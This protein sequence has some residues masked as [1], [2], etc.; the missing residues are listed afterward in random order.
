M[1]Y[2][3]TEVTN[4]LSGG[5]S[6]V[7]DYGVL[8][9]ND[10]IYFGTV[11]GGYCYLVEVNKQGSSRAL[12][13]YP[14]SYETDFGPDDYHGS[15]ALEW[16]EKGRKILTVGGAHGGFKPMK[17]AV[18]DVE[19][20]QIVASGDFG[21][22][23]LT[24]PVLVKTSDG[25]ISLFIC[26]YDPSLGYR[27]IWWYEFDPT[28]NTWS[29]PV[30]I[31]V[32]E[33]K[34]VYLAGWNIDRGWAILAFS[35]PGTYFEFA[36]VQFDPVNKKF[37]DLQ[38][39]ELTPPFDH[40]TL[41]SLGARS[42]AILNNYVY[43]I[44]YDTNTSV[45]YAKKLTLDLSEIKSVELASASQGLNTAYMHELALDLM[46]YGSSE[47]LVAYR[48]NS[49]KLEIDVLDPDTLTPEKVFESPSSDIPQAPHFENHYEGA[50]VWFN[51][52][53]T[54]GERN[55]NLEASDDHITYV[56]FIDR[57]KI[58]TVLTLR[59]VPL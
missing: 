53:D 13:L 9:N 56:D 6:F 38:G 5:N 59:V 33:T 12:Q 26:Y 1:S 27:V 57:A 28:T 50:L 39:N 58:S 29:G 52:I 55:W 15:P 31:T 48:N 34:I 7:R 35:L 51:L 20:W 22:T 54:T 41:P 17:W 46:V 44:L 32:Q 49:N 18:V 10:K 43:T 37:Y 14:N 40:T 2:T 11:A 4:Q 8:R 25:K 3:V 19:N 21:D 47:I 23:D 36:Y 42:M 45:V 16:I 30:K 24:Y